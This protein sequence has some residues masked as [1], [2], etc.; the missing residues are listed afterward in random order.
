MVLIYN[1]KA[2]LSFY[3]RTRPVYNFNNAVEMLQ[4]LSL[5]EIPYLEMTSQYLLLFVWMYNPQ[6]SE[7]FQIKQ[8][9]IRGV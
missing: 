8:L 1:F 7:I 4:M 2:L 3:M 5:E 9:T 6:R